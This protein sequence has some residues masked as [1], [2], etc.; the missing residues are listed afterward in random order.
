[1]LDRPGMPV[2]CLG[3]LLVDQAAQEVDLALVHADVVRD[4]ALSDD[5][6]VDAAQIDAAGDV[7]DIDIHVHGDVA[8]IVDPGGDV[9]R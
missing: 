1:M 9:R 5:G 8:V 2:I 7:G 3:V 4:L 6:L